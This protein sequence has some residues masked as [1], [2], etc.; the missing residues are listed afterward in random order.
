M[1]IIDVMRRKIITIFDQV[2]NVIIIGAPRSGTNML[3]DV[4]TSVE[5]VATWPCDEINYMWRHGNKSQPS[6]EFSVDKARA[7]VRKYIRRQF[8]GV[9]QKYLAHTVVEKT[10][11]NS[12]RVSFVNG[13]F[14]NSKYIFL[15]RDGRD[16]ILSTMKRWTA[17]L[18]IPYLLKKAKFV[19]FSD[20]PYYASLYF[21]N[22]VKKLLSHE[23]KLAS[24][25]PRFEGIDEMVRSKSLL[26]VCAV[27]W[28]RC[29][30][31]SLDDFDNIDPI[32]IHTV[33]YEDF[34]CK[35][36][37]QM[38]ALIDFLDITLPDVEIKN[39]IHGVSPKS[40]GNWK[41][42]FSTKDLEIINPLI[43]KPM[44]RLGYF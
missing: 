8:G 26:E 38:K 14:P 20:V 28:A 43:K 12:L 19:P 2:S 9:A 23:K 35:P 32:R 11:A 4:L 17:S 30:E 36:K 33:K 42:G 7:E 1:R 40:V 5:G 41:R 22:R 34:V 29:V 25:G 37:L 44:R 39:L 13:V 21:V 31:K 18:D 15:Y 3:R 16:A 27:Q 24:W 6:D 10:C